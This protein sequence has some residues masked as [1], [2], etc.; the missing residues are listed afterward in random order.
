MFLS[1]INTL[2]Y[3]E[4]WLRNDCTVA[5]LVINWK[6]VFTECGSS[7]INL[8][9]RIGLST[10]PH[11]SSKV[12][13][14]PSWKALWPV[15]NVLLF[16]SLMYDD[17]IMILSHTEFSIPLLLCRSAIPISQFH[18]WHKHIFNGIPILCLFSWSRKVFWQQDGI[19]RGNQKE[20]AAR[21]GLGMVL[22]LLTPALALQAALLL[23]ADAAF[24]PAGQRER[25]CKGLDIWWN[26]RVKLC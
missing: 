19:S 16:V 15:T 2:H 23:L 3:I 4:G 20:N 18:T 12:T 9:S 10:A 13:P 7:Q 21:Q 8:G 11:I 14:F 17:Q 1:E 22:L 5:D 6:I 26:R 24:C 25:C